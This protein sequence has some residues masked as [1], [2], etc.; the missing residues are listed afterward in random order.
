VVIKRIL[1]QDTLDLTFLIE[2]DSFNFITE[3][4][5]SFLALKILTFNPLEIMMISP[6]LML[7]EGL[8]IVLLLTALITL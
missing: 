1:L 8:V 4:L 5:N 2:F 7:T 3:V 6:F